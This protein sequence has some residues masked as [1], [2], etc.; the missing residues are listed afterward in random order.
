L[1][2]FKSVPRKVYLLGILISLIPIVI[3]GIARITTPQTDSF[4]WEIQYD[5]F[6]YAA[7]AREMFENGNFF[8]Y[9]NPFDCL[10]DSPVIYSHLFPLLVGSIWKLTNLPIMFVY[11]PIRIVFGV[12]FIITVWHLATLFFQNKRVAEIAFYCLMI[13]GGGIST[14]LGLMALVTRKI[15]FAQFFQ[16]LAYIE[17]MAGW[18]F[19]NIFRNF[20]YATEILYHFLFFLTL[21]LVVK[22]YWRLSLLFLALMLYAHPYTGFQL[23][24][25]Y[26]SY[27]FLSFFLEQEE[28]KKYL[29]F[30]ICASMLVLIFIGY[31]V[32]WLRSFPQHEELMNE[33]MGVEYAVLGFRKLIICWGI[34]LWFGFYAAVRYFKPLMSSREWRLILILL[35][36]SFTLVNHHYITP[37]RVQPAHFSHGYVFTPLV[38]LTFYLYE[39][40]IRQK[41]RFT[42]I[43]Q[44]PLLI[45]SFVIITALDNV[46][47]LPRMYAMAKLPPAT[48]TRT[49]RDMLQFLST[50]QKRHVVATTNM[51]IGYLVTVF[52]QHDAVIGYLHHTPRSDLKRNLLLD[53][54]HK[55]DVTLLRQYKNVDVLILSLTEKESI[56]Q[57]SFFAKWKELFHNETFYIYLAN[58]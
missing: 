14:W 25:V 26:M 16:N 3:M 21:V 50:Q 32:L 49:E 1:F 58:S 23:G 9:P 52:T 35:G 53:L 29:L 45:S 19:L 27:F 56:S 41:S 31:N 51:S 44:N 42:T 33:L 2:F 12:L 4:N 20:F 28:K 48:I 18:W 13:S 40:T 11:F 34:W 24:L 7:N 10:D 55:G 39:R 30:G 43:L 46:C 37:Y 54:I 47:Y 38:M 15:A 22:K 57:Y 8:A 36:V 6:Y 5:Q 17:G